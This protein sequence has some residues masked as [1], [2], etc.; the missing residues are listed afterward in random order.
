LQVAIAV[1]VV[2]PGS[3][4]Y[5]SLRKPFDTRFHAVLPRAVVL[6]K[7]PNDVAETLSVTVR[8]G[9]RTATRSGGHCFAG[10]S[11]TD[12]I[13]IDV[14]PMNAV[15]VAGDNATIG[16]GARLGDVYR[17]LR[18]H[19]RTIPATSCPSVGI[20]GL[21]LGGG[22]GILGRKYGVTSDHLL[23]AQ[24]VLAD[25]TVASSTAMTLTRASCFGRSVAPARAILESSLR[26]S[27]ARSRRRLR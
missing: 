18:Q 27:F 11:S 17:S 1:K 14:R 8:A 23:G 5:E 7:T 19:D 12:G 9:L 4:E 6:C 13:V 24:V 15:S 25:G 22:L 21:T 26:L 16:A 20:A 10:H 3:P 2:L